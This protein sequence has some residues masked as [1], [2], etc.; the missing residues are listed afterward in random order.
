VRGGDQAK[1][2]ASSGMLRYH[3]QPLALTLARRFAC[4]GAEA[5]E[6]RVDVTKHTP[7]A[8][9]TRRYQRG[10]DVSTAVPISP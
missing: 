3:H 2:E 10:W 5:L 8:T 7:E 6:E 4:A 9:E 1:A